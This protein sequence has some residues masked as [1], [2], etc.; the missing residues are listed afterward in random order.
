MLNNELMKLPFYY[1]KLLP[2]LSYV[3]GNI[4]GLY[5]INIGDKDGLHDAK[6]Y[7]DPIIQDIQNKIKQANKLARKLAKSQGR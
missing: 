3:Q 5:S 1:S 4:D 2:N 7:I 6:Q